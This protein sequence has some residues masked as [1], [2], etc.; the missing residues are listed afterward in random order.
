[1][2]LELK[3]N[4][5]HGTKEYPYCQ[6][7]MHEINH[8]FQVPVHWHEEVEIIYIKQG[9]LHVMINGQN[10]NGTSGSVYLVNPR[11]LHLMGSSDRSVDYYTLL[12]PM[13]FISFQSMDELESELLQPLRSG[14]LLFYNVL[15]DDDAGILVPLLEEIIAANH[16]KYP[17]RQ[18]QTRVLLLQFLQALLEKDAI[19]RPTTGSRSSMQKEMLAFIQEHY[20]EKITLQALAEHFHLSEKYISHYFKEHF[21]L[22]FSNY[23]NHLRLTHAKRLLE[24]TDLPVT[25]VAPRS[26]FPS[27]SYFIRAFKTSC[28]V[29]PLKYRKLFY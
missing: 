17:Y 4:R 7:H 5:P 16:S 8:E 2:N 20:T 22:T 9:Q 14:Q 10:Y 18:I 23:V 19:L 25:E 11:E 24:T 21:H 28:G 1:M 29:S 6:Y 27:V 12:F 26:G 13:E 3:E 15:L